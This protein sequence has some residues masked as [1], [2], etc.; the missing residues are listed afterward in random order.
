MKSLL[1]IVCL[2]TSHLTIFGQDWKRTADNYSFKHYQIEQGLSDNTVYCALQ[3]HHG[4]LWFGTKNGLNRFDGYHFKDIP[5]TKESGRQQHPNRVQCIFEDSGRQLWLGGEN[6]L[7]RYDAEKDVVTLIADTISSVVSILEDRHKQIWIVGGRSLYRYDRRT[8]SL[9]RYPRQRYFG[10]TTLSLAGDSTLWIGSADGKIYHYLETTDEFQLFDLYDHSPPPSVPEIT[11]LTAYGPNSILVGTRAQGVKVFD[12]RSGSYTDLLNADDGVPLY[13]RDIVAYDSLQFWCATETGLYILDFASRTIRHVQK[14]ETDEFSLS[15]NAV[16]TMCRDEDGGMWLGTYF[17]GVNYYCTPNALFRKQYYRKDGSRF[18]DHV[19]RDIQPDGRQGLWLSTEDDGLY[20]YSYAADRIVWHGSTDPPTGLAAKNI[21][22]LMPDGP[23]LW[24]GTYEYGIDLMDVATHRVIRHYEKGKNGNQLRSNFGITFLKSRS[25]VLY[26][27]TAGGLFSYNKLLDRFDSV[28]GAPFDLFIYSLVEDHNGRIL[29]GSNQKSVY[30]FDPMTH[31]SVAL[32]DTYPFHISAANISSLEDRQGRLWFATEENGVILFEPGT[33]KIRRFTETE[34]L[35]SNYTFKVQE[36]Q[37]GSIWVSTNGGLTRI[38]ADGTELR[39]FSTAD[40]LLS[41]QFNF[42]S[43]YTDDSGRLYFGS[44][45]GLISFRPELIADR[46]ALKKVFLT[47]IQVNNTELTAADANNPLHGS[48]FAVREI[49]LP[50]NRSTV[51]FDFAAINYQAPEMIRYRY[52]LEGLDE[53]WT[54]LPVNRRVYYTSLPPG[55]YRFSVQASN[56]PGWDGPTASLALIIRPPLWATWYAYLVYCLIAVGLFYYFN[57]LRRRAG[58]VK[59]EKEIFDA[60]LDFF[61]NV[62]HEVKTPLTLIK[63]PLDQLKKQ[64]AR[65]P[66]ISNDVQ[67]LE[68]NTNRLIALIQQILDLR[69]TETKRFTLELRKVNVSRLLDEVLSLYEAYLSAYGIRC[70]TIAHPANI[71]IDA[72]EEALR[73][74]I[75]NLVDNA[76]KH[77]ESGVIIELT[78]DVTANQLKMVIEN[79]GTGIPYSLKEKIFEPFFSTGNARQ[80]GGT[81]IGLALVKSFTDLHNGQIELAE[82]DANHTRFVLILPITQ[83]KR[84]R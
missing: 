13:V 40:G 44:L 27:G 58:Q 49:T 78:Q 79:D 59:K 10:A 43:G 19:V 37:Q 35:S 45:R 25:G 81:G 30:L 54:V 76:V 11:R 71:I 46:P 62:A 65:Y 53:R 18:Q 56:S 77:A 55:H 8:Q 73:K 12:T 47:N 67:T 38:N 2:L 15:G 42:N 66:E 68:K 16:Y 63:L 82:T 69:K 84:K 20:Q 5:L 26:A 6:A 41:D 31:R 9:H 72:D 83:Y 1:P 23:N 17:A 7:Y 22:G 75:T 48:A 29:I 70:E 57:R 33:G 3:D 24:I 32:T 34:G 61:T 52:R 21:H 64:S 14:Q 36:D 80:S 28:A 74:V 51:S 39:R 4:F 60:K 50:H